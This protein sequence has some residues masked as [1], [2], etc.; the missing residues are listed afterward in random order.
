MHSLNSGWKL[1]KLIQREDGQCPNWTV[2]K[3]IFI[4]IV[5]LS[6]PEIN[7]FKIQKY[8]SPPLNEPTFC[9]PKAG[10]LTDVYCIGL[11]IERCIIVYLSEFWV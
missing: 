5:F 10:L 7:H 6:E 1:N 4:P 8:K 11:R 9:C 3:T 2:V